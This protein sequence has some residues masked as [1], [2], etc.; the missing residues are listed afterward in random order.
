MYYGMHYLVG[1]FWF[2]L[3]IKIVVIALLVYVIYRMFKRSDLRSDFR[4]HLERDRSLAILKERF[5]KGEITEEEYTRM[6]SLLVEEK[7]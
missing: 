2:L 7:K 1:F 5:A 4:S 3:I 6:K